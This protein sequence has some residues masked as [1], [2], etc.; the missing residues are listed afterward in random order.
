MRRHYLIDQ[1]KG[2]TQLER[3]TLDGTWVPADGQKGAAFSGMLGSTPCAW[4]PKCECFFADSCPGS[5][6]MD[7]TA[8]RY[9]CANG[10][11]VG[12]TRKAKK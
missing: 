11:T 12:R 8:R 9:R 1:P 2:A 10:R 7:R 5:M 3:L 6:A 4:K